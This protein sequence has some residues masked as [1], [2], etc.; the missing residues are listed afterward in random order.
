[1]VVAEL[2]VGRRGVV[3]ALGLVVAIVA[4]LGAG[5]AVLALGR[6]RGR[7]EDLLGGLR[8]PVVEVL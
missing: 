5:L 1:M 8:C 4:R 3:F 7:G 2:V 6:R